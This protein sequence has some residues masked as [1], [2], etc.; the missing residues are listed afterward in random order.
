M[1]STDKNLSPVLDVKNATFVMGRSKINAP[2]DNYVTDTRSTRID[3]DP[4]GSI[5][6]TN[7]VNLSQPATS[8]KV[9][10]GANVQS[11]ADFR[12]YYRLFSS[13]SSEVSSTYRLF[14]GHKNLLDTDG[15]GFGDQ[16]IDPAMND[17]S[18]DALVSK[19][20]ADDFSEYQFTVDNLEPFDG[21]TIKVVMSSTNE[22]VPVRLKDFRA[23]S[24]A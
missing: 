13:S 15:D 12:V 18:A 10:L 3:N 17:G 16:I 19:N 5:F 20:G 21:F 9:L 11:E 7:Q 14:P 8:L 1:T 22:C 2:V 23:I 4:H 6:V 24:L